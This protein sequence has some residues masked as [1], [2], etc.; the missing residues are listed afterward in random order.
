MQNILLN[1]AL[2]A[3]LK[4]DG[5]IVFD[6]LSA[7]ELNRLQQ[8]YQ[9]W[10]TTPPAEFYK[11]YFSDNAAYKTEVEELILELFTPKLK[12]YFTGYIPYGGMF[13]VKPQGERGHFPP[14]QDW[15]FVDERQHWSLNMW[16]PLTDVDAANGNMQMLPGS[17]LFLHTIRGSGTPDQYEGQKELVQPHMLDIPMRAGQAI[18]FYH[19]IL[20]GSTPNTQ[21][22]ERVSVGLSLIEEGAPVYY[23]YTHP[24]TSNTEAFEAHLDFYKNYVS[25]R[26]KLPTTVRSLGFT[27]FAFPQL[28]NEE[29]LQ[30][31]KHSKVTV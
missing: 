19:G 8:C 18:F 16:C 7:A 30:K 15:S 11:S 5:Y 6:M 4:R 10:H 26:D 24:G 9:K 31:I 25:D 1:P 29:L 14:H 13:V 23:H 3:Q 20:H 28:T 21:P 12:Q 22:Q 2:D 27:D 17:H